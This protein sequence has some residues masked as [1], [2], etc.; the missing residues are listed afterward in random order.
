VSPDNWESVHASNM[1]D[2]GDDLQMSMRK[3]IGA[4]Q[5]WGVGLW[6][7]HVNLSVEFGVTRRGEE[8]AVQIFEGI[9]IGG[10][11]PDGEETEEGSFA[12]VEVGTGCGLTGLGRGMLTLGK[13]GFLCLA[14]IGAILVDEMESG[15]ILTGRGDEVDGGL[16]WC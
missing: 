16:Q 1:A 13:G 9:I 12:G 14:R 5:A 4:S 2:A 10:G 7:C 11:I 3:V 15:G 6:R 8:R